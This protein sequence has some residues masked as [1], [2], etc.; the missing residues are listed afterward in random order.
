MRDKGVAHVIVGVDDS[1]AGLEALR[2]AVRLARGLG[3]GLRAVRA[4]T[5]PPAVDS[6]WGA[7]PEWSPAATRW[8]AYE[9][10]A[11]DFMLHAFD[12]ALGAPPRDI[13]VEGIIAFATP[14]RVL[15]ESA[16]EQDVLVV[17]ASRPRGWWPWRW[18][19]FHRS[20]GAYC[21]AHAS[22]PVLIVPPH[23]AARELDP[24]WAPLGWLRRRHELSSMLGANF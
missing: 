21:A 4:C 18:R 7:V 14:R 8:D 24:G 11:R 20:V 2:E 17:G 10:Q 19:L 3:M 6:E 15:A 1:L 23:A 13:K 9:R 16:L 22:C 12:E 5:S